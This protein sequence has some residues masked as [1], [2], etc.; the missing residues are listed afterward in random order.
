MKNLEKFGIEELNAKE[1]REI[2]GGLWLG[3]TFKALKKFAKWVG[4][5]DV[6]DDFVEGWN[7]VEPVC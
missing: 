4:L 3:G 7:S 6:V 1:I 5:F 2:D